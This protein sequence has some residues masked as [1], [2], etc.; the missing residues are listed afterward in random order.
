MIA[1]CDHAAFD[2]NQCGK[3]A[4][5]FYKSRTNHYILYA[6]CSQH[7][8]MFPSLWIKITKKEYVKLINLRK[9]QSVMDA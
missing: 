1:V 5:L 4:N 2:E 7:S 6:R 9:I 8:I 3:K